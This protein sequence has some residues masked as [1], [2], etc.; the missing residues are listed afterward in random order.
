VK[1]II[2]LKSGL[3]FT[4]YDFVNINF[5]VTAFNMVQRIKRAVSYLILDLELNYFREMIS[6]KITSSEFSSNNFQNL[7]AASRELV[8]IN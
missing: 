6:N 8:N 5:P 2:R 4:F 3:V 7:L 1:F